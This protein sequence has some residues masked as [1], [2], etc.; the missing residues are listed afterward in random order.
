MNTAYK[1]RVPS[2]FQVARK[3][4]VPP[5]EKTDT[6]REEVRKLLGTYDFSATF[7]IDDQTA[8]TLKHIPGLIAFLCTIKKGDKVIG[9]GRGATVIN[10]INRFIVRTINYAFNASLV[11]GI[12]RSTK[13][14]DVFRPDAQ[15]HP[16][17]GPSAPK[18]V[19][20]GETEQYAGS[21]DSITDKQKSYL[22][23]LIQTNVS[24]EDDREQ[25][26]SQLGEMS[27]D[28]AS[29]AIQSFK[30]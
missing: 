22:L 3:P 27:R 6:V 29:E 23:Q 1:T 15:Q 16:W 5:V 18:P 21:G 10:Q 30:R 9:I 14:L 7:E 20:Y 25:Q 26:I 4:Y 13:I 12:V 19:S 8:T 17:N 28:E 11:D 2:P 24:D